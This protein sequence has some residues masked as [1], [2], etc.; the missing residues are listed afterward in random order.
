MNRKDLIS[1]LISGFVI[2]ASCDKPEKPGE[3][4][5]PSPGGSNNTELLVP[6]ISGEYYNYA[7]TNQP[8][9]P[10]MLEYHNSMMVKM[11]M[12]S[13]KMGMNEDYT[14]GAIGTNVNMTYTDVINNIRYMDAI[15]R[16]MHKIVY[17]VGWQYNGH[18]DQYPAFWGFNSSLTG[19]EG[20][21]A[22]ESYLNVQKKAKEEYNTTVSVH[23]NM[24]DAR[25]D[26][27]YWPT[28]VAN[29]MLCR[30]KHGDFCNSG[31]LSFGNNISLPNYEVCLVN[32][33]KKGYTAD[34]IHRVIDAC[35]LKY[36]KT[37]H[38]DA[39]KPY[40]S[41][42]HG[43][44]LDDADQVMRKII[45]YFRDQGVDVTT[46]FWQDFGR[47]DRFIGLSPACW[48]N[49]FTIEDRV[50]IHPKLACGGEAGTW[51]SG[52]DW[53]HIG[54]LFGETPH[55]ETYLGRSSDWTKFTH[56][57]CTLA[58]QYVLLNNHDL[59]T[60]D[61][62]KG[63]ATYSGGI[64]VNY[65]AKSL[66]INGKLF[67]KSN[68][69]F[70]PALWIKDHKEIIAYSENGYS[71]KTWDL[72]ADWSGVSS[73]EVWKVTKDGLSDK[74]TIDVVR[75]RLTLSLDKGQMLSVQAVEK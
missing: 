28:Y 32:E 34:R 73:V 69:V 13:P 43:Y 67:R 70:L 65:P 44:T 30:N 54:F 19:G 71:S 11:F 7:L 10:Y 16:G 52:Q 23:I 51:M 31:N 22:K 42:Y 21:S 74:R 46:E 55:C 49:N 20:A 3:G 35:N 2:A 61:F 14:Y 48:W 38:I 9:R 17:L 57:F 4:D 72:P 27:F 40:K 29:D 64:V 6:E 58:V 1:L 26:S 12:S 36:A 25:E 24:T 59:L 56:E 60:Y 39:F 75:G 50:G 45:R 8:E 66:E 68:D 53:N 37:V 63:V 47:V 18:D 41:E 62:N 5:R 15:S 33:W